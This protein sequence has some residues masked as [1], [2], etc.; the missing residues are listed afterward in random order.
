MSVASALYGPGNQLINSLLTGYKIF[1]S[2][3]KIS[4]S[5]DKKVDLINNVTCRTT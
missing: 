5:R 3:D 2:Y 4:M 1:M